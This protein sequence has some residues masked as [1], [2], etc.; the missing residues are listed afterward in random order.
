MT[1]INVAMIGQGFMGRT[2]SNAWGQVAKFFQP[3]IRP[4]LYA[5]FGQPEENPH[6][7][8]D[9]WGWQ[10]A[11]TNWE[12]LVALPDVGLVD[13]VTPTYAQC[14]VA[15]AAVT[16][17]KHCACEKP[18]T[19]TLAEA[20]QLAEAAKAAQVKTFVWY[21]YRRCPAVA[22]AHRLVQEG[23][24]GVIRH[25]RATYLQ[26]WAPESTP[27]MWRFRRNCVAAAHTAI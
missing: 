25:V 18:L 16:A 23:R 14:T 3:P 5:V 6:K 21:N 20:R 22:L 8:A 17:G 12:E 7:F 26:D 27:L 1:T 24:I 10:N 2:H 4:V 13:V 11:S 9:N 15:L 19:A